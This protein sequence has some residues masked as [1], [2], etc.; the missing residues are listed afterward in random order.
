M[1]SYPILNLNVKRNRQV[2]GAYLPVEGGES[3]GVAL[4]SLSDAASIA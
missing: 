2:R 3:K 4:L 1:T